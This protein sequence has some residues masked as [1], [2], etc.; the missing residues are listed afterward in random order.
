MVSNTEIRA[1]A[2][3]TNSVEVVTL[4]LT[5]VMTVPEIRP[6]VAEVAFK[7]EVV[8]KLEVEMR[9]EVVRLGVEPT[10]EVDLRLEAELKPEVVLRVGFELTFEVA[11]RLKVELKP[12]VTLLQSSI[13]IGQQV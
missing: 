7:L 9:P 12:V 2:M 1:T 4:S 11:L 6:A 5:K 13:D 10:L 3:L 8:L